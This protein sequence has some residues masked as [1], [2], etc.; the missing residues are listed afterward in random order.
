MTMLNPCV[1]E[2]PPQT[3]TARRRVVV[4]IVVVE[5]VVDSTIDNLNPTQND[6][7]H[8]HHHHLDNEVPLLVSNF[9]NPNNIIEI[10]NNQVQYHG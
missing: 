5:A 9:P 10:R 7:H 8:H 6:L 2:V 3:Q 1:V 4:V